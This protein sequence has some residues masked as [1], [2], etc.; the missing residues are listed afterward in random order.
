MGCESCSKSPPNEDQIDYK[1]DEEKR[2]EEFNEKFN[3][4]LFFNHT[5]KLIFI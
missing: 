4:Y 2:K 1:K 5:K 3:K